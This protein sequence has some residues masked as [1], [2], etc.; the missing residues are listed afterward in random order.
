MPSSSYT[1][2]TVGVGGS[3]S[4]ALTAPPRAPVVSSESA[5]TETCSGDGRAGADDPSGVP[6]A[7]CSSDSSSP[8]ASRNCASCS[9]F[10]VRDLDLLCVRCDR[11]VAAQHADSHRCTARHTLTRMRSR[12]LDSLVRDMRRVSTMAANSV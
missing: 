7:P 8:P 4:S 10:R 3:D 6:H 1:V 2:M 5:M 12:V 11:D 9:E